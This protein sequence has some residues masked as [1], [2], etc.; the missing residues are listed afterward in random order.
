M[1]NHRDR[2]NRASLAR[3][4]LTHVD[5]E[6]TDPSAIRFSMDAACLA[7]TSDLQGEKSC[8][9]ICNYALMT[10]R[11][12]ARAEY[13]RQRYRYE[14]EIGAG[15]SS[16]ILQI[17]ITQSEQKFPSPSFFFF[18]FFFSSSLGSFGRVERERNVKRRR[19]NT[20]GTV[21]SV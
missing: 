17:F 14:S 2:N 12:A 16:Q 19:G 21:R 15:Y 20:F 4:R 3:S 6:R 13:R 10:A 11:I 7:T 8:Y 18:F 5:D 1:R 9:L